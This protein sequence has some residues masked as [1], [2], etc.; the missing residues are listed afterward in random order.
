M[1]QSLTEIAPRLFIGENYLSKQQAL[2]TVKNLEEQMGWKDATVLDYNGGSINKDIRR[3]QLL[4][5]GSEQQIQFA[6]D[7]STWKD[8]LDINQNVEPYLLEYQ[9]TK[10]GGMF[11]WHPDFYEGSGRVLSCLLYL[12]D[13]E[14]HGLEGGETEFMC[15]EEIITI[16]PKI[17]TVLL[18]DPK[19]IH[20]GTEVT[21]GIKYSLLVIHGNCPRT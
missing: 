14:S 11:G 9:V 10:I 7:V 5:N 12:S 20:Q 4:R 8:L 21:A 19:I 3:Q 2:A 13:N 17:G 16:K 6:N 18:F 15:E 1:R